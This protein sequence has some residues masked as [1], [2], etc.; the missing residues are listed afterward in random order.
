MAYIQEVKNINKMLQQS[1]LK[2]WVHYENTI[3][4]YL[5]AKQ[6]NLSNAKNIVQNITNI[7]HWGGRYLRIKITNTSKISYLRGLIE[8][9]YA[10]SK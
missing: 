7:G 2:N 6:G 8:P 1:V 9:V 10:K 5:K 4:E 3:D